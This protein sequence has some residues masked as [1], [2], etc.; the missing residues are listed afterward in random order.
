MI[1]LKHAVANV[2][3]SFIISVVALVLSGW[4]AYTDT[5]SAPHVL[6]SF[7]EPAWIRLNAAPGS[8]TGEASG[9]V[10]IVATCSFT[11]TGARTGIVE[12]VLLRVQSDDGAEKWLFFPLF[13]IDNS[14]MLAPKQ[15]PGAPAAE[16]GI[17][18]TNALSG[19]FYP[20]AVS[21]K[22]SV[23]FTYLFQPVLDVP[24]FK[25]AKL[26]P[27]SYQITALSRMA[28]ENAY[29]ESQQLT[30]KILPHSIDIINSQG[31]LQVQGEEVHKARSAVDTVRPLPDWANGA[32]WG[33]LL[34]FVLTVL[35]PGAWIL[36]LKRLHEPVDQAVLDFLGT[37]APGDK[38][39][40]GEISVAANM[41]RENVERSLKRLSSKSKAVEDD[42]QGRWWKVVMYKAN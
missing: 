37:L 13:Q 25:Y 16:I 7:N 21:G 29:T 34:T 32:I 11:N 36:L 3:W 24:N 39:T 6:L 8:T 15:L 35:L 2:S 10:G 30:V 18:L 1:S 17:D 22:Q 5:F 33:A 4:V 31:I 9:L 20:V 28:G 12:D 42:G 14:K 23:A 40:V 27:H 19:R 38:K 26:T 41:T